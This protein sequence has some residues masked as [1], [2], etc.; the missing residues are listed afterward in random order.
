MEDMLLESLTKH[1]YATHNVSQ[2]MKMVVTDLTFPLIHSHFTT[3]GSSRGDPM[4]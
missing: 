4:L 3:V 2:D 1:G